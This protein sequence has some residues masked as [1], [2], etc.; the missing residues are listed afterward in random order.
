MLTEL[1]CKLESNCHIVGWTSY[2]N[3]RIHIKWSGDI[4]NFSEKEDLSKYEKSHI[5]SPTYI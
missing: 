3:K 2:Q 1:L 4:S 5:I